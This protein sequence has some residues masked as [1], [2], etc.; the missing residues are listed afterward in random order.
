MTET[1]VAQRELQKA[2][3]K[4][5]SEKIK[6]DVLLHRQKELIEC[7]GWVSEVGASAGGSRTAM[8]IDSVRKQ[9]SRTTVLNEN[10]PGSS[11]GSVDASSMGEVIQMQELLGQGSFGKVF[12]GQWR[13]LT[14]AV[15]SMTLP[16]NMSGDERKQRMALMEAAIS[17][18]LVHCNIIKTHT[19]SIKPI[20]ESRP[21]SLSEAPS[22]STILSPQKAA[23]S[24]AYDPPNRKLSMSGSEGAISAFE[25]QIVLEY[26]DLGTLRGALT[27]GVFHPSSSPNYRL[28]LE[29]ALGIASGMQH[30]HL[31]NI[32]HADLK[33]SNILLQSS[34]ERSSITAKIADFGLSI[35]KVDASETHVSGMYQGRR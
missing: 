3:E 18:S 32:I 12:K 4:L 34:S 7:L 30:L 2:H 16:I 25:V 10:G 26:C 27:A 24:N 19:Y 5:E 9:L 20:R 1:V 11:S 31:S 17:S 8:L 33:A 6:M 29:V 21:Q 23:M 28:I 35:S 14:V 15:K 22:I 13:G